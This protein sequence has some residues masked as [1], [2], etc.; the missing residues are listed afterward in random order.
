MND[1][2]KEQREHSEPGSEVV[3]TKDLSY[4]YYS[5]MPKDKR[6]SDIYY[7]YKLKEI[8]ELYWIYIS[9]CFLSVAGDAIELNKERTILTFLALLYT[10]T[11]TA[12]RIVAQLLRKRYPKSYGAHLFLFYVLGQ[13]RFVALAYFKLQ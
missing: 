4:S 13:M 10:T 7:N 11:A 1:Q 6:E 2:Q 9:T 8:S 12:L 3:M 5:L